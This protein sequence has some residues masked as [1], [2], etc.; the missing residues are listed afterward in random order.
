MQRPCSDAGIALS[1]SIFCAEGSAR[2]MQALAMTVQSGSAAL[3][4]TVGTLRQALSTVLESALRPGL[5]GRDRSSQGGGAAQR[6]LRGRC[7]RLR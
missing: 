1:M 4:W 5:T 3:P 6:A 7:G 2:L